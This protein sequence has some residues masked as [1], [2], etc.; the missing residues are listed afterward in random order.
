MNSLQW[1]TQK[2]PITLKVRDPDLP[3]QARM[4]DSEGR[5]GLPGFVQPQVETGCGHCQI[6]Y[7]ELAYA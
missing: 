5:A 1:P 6:A 4:H 2:V 3:R 7:V